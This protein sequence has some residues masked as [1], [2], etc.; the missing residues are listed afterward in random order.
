VLLV[1]PGASVLPDL[2]AKL[3][4]R[5]L[6]VK[7]DQEVMSGVQPEIQVPLDLLVQSDTLDQKEIQEELRDTKVK[8]V[9]RVTLV[10]L[11][12]EE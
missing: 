11:V 3:A 8:L 6:Q 7:K 5:V 2:R 9:G 1:K 12:R 10:Q 4:Q